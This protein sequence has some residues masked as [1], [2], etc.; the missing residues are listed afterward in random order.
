[1][2]DA[3]QHFWK[4]E[5]ADYSW[6]S[7]DMG[8]LYQ[9]YL[10]EN[11]QPLLEKHNISG[12]VL[13]QAAPTYE[14]TLFLLSLYERYD[15]ICG[16]VG[17]LDLASPSFPKQLQSIMKQP[18]IVG[19][20]P[21]LQDIE[22]NDWILQDQVMENLKWLI[23]YNL[24]LDLLINKKHVPSILTLVQALPDLL[25]VIDHMAKP[26][27]AGRELN[28][29][30]EEMSALAQFPNVWCKLSGLMTEAKPFA[31]KTE[32]FEPYIHHIVQTFGSSRLLFGS[33]WPV[34][35]SAGSYEEALQIISENLPE[36]VKHLEADKIFSEN[37]KA[38]YKLK[39]RRENNE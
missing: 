6:L 39:D 29:W 5:R 30:K 9:D 21:M 37:A 12:T 23:Q 11:L 13:V 2:I 3:H 27:I 25:T 28:E 19:L 1:M 32:D 18:G 26:N 34:C 15:W 24:P 33:D 20:R 16:V 38:F 10:P 22:Q 4:L 14:E 36:T 35:L 7:K 17:W 8:V 31:W